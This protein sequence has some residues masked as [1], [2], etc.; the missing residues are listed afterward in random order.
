MLIS[1]AN[2]LRAMWFRATASRPCSGMARM[3]MAHLW[4]RLCR[5][6]P[7]LP[8]RHATFAQMAL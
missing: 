8:S 4:L 2:I 3:A 6:A 5:T 1:L 7:Q